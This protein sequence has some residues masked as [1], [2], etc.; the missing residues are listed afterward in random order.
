M[1]PL[2]KNLDQTIDMMQSPNYKERF[3][4]EYYQLA[5]RCKK[6]EAMLEKW[7]NGTLEFTPTCN[8][9]I[10]NFQVRAMKDY[11]TALESRAVMEGV[12]LQRV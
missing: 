7:D 3:K 12:H 10:Y 4:A 9:S 11:M 2:I 1:E 8:R 6:L 5:I